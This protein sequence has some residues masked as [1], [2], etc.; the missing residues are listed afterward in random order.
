MTAAPFLL[1]DAQW[2][3]IAPLLPEP[4]RSSKGGPHF[5]GNRRCFEGILWILWTGAQWR[6]LPKEYPSPAT[7]WR[8]L[9]RWMDEG[10]W[11]KA[12]ATFVRRLKRR[13]QLRWDE[14]FI[15]AM[16]A[17]AKK[18]APTSEKP[19]KAREQRWWWWRTLRVFQSVTTYV[20]LPPTSPSSPRRRS[21][22]RTANRND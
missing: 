8:R 20:R 9:K 18:G 16:F 11:E 13:D 6:A 7:C 14:T 10:V 3:Q 15:D 4:K 22:R 5:I 2:K 12:F 1:T 17:P 21:R 19:R